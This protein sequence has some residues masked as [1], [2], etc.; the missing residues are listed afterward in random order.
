MQQQTDEVAGARQDLLPWNVGPLA[1]FAYPFGEYNADTLSIVRG[2]GYTS[3]AATITGYVG[4]G[5]DPIQLEHR[6]CRSDLAPGAMRGW[7]DA[8]AANRGWL[9][10]TFHGIDTSGQLYNCT[11]AAFQDIVD[12]VRSRGLP[13][14]T[15]TQGMDSLAH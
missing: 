1:S 15:V 7:V 13:V 8:A 9:I 3:A 10:M 14:V 2:A 6:E 11:P 4:P 5:S 12:Y